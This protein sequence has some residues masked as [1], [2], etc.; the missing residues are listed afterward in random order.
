MLCA[1]LFDL[2]IKDSLAFAHHFTYLMLRP[3]DMF[4]K[5]CVIPNSSELIQIALKVED[6]KA[7]DKI[8]SNFKKIF[9]GLRLKSDG[10]NYYKRTEP[11]V[12]E[13]IPPSITDCKKATEYMCEYKTKPF[14]DGLASIGANQNIV[15]VNTNHVCADGGFLMYALEHCFDDNITNDFEVPTTMEEAYKQQCEIIKKNPPA[16]LRYDKLTRIKLLDSPDLE[17]PGTR[18]RYLVDQFPASKLQCFDRKKNRPIHLSESLWNAMALSLAAYENISDHLAL[19]ICFDIRKYTNP[20]NINF[21]YCNHFCTAN[22]HAPSINPDIS[23]QQLGEQFRNDFSM[24]FNNGALMYT[25]ILS[26]NVMNYPGAVHGNV[27]NLGP[28]RFK[29]PIE[30]LYLSSVN[31]GPGTDLFLFLLTYGKVSETMN[32]IVTRFRFSP[33]TTSQ[34]TAQII[35]DSIKHVITEIPLSA[36]LHDVLRELRDFQCKLKKSY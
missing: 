23:L 7:L 8:I 19:C 20:S 16:L 29:K 25:A 2:L 4:E 1:F 5:Y 10:V 27:S 34:K 21:S 3:L 15:C 32:D 26:E 36:K 24:R 28:V 22:I 11:I 33:A 13:K 9:M 18:C 35:Q 14:T 12:L 6:P 31:E 30:D 17:P